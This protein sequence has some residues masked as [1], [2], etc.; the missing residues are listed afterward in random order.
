MPLNRTEKLNSLFASVGER[1]K[2]EYRKL[3]LKG[4]GHNCL[5]SKFGPFFIFGQ[6]C[7]IFGM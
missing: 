2:A 4:R 6:I 5:M 3:H 1:K 7:L